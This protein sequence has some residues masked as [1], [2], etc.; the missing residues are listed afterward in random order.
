M[1]VQRLKWKEGTDMMAANGE[2]NGGHEGKENVRCEIAKDVRKRDELATE[3]TDG[4]K[5]KTTKRG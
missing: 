1:A 4:D 2:E 3:E 5:I